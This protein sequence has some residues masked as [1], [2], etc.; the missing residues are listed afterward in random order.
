MAMKNYFSLLLMSALL[1]SCVNFSGVES[2][3]VTYPESRYDSSDVKTTIGHDVA[4]PYGW[5][6][7]DLSEE[8][9]QWVEAQNAV[10]FAHL[11]EIP[12]RAALR[13]RL[14]ALWNYAKRGAPFIEGDFRYFYR[15]DGLQS[16]YILYRVVL[17]GDEADAEVFLNP[18]T[19]SADGTTSLGGISFSPDGSLVAYQIS[20]GGSDWRKVI[21]L[22]AVTGNRLGDTLA[23]IKFSGLAWQCRLL[24]QLV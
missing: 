5:L 6:E 7:D 22:D 21:I 14:S 2:S 23:D 19:F 15:N 12:F 18:N 20:E 9:A 3:P 11:E 13:D 17:D 10:T 1:A 24:L 8:T 4:D 16:Q